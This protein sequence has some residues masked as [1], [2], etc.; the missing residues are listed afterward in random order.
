[1]SLLPGISLSLQHLR[2]L[3]EAKAELLECPSCSQERRIA[4]YGAPHDNTFSEN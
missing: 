2:L 1:M 3:V 4:S